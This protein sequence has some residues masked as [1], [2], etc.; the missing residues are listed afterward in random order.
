M[1]CIMMKLELL[2][3]IT[4]LYTTQTTSILRRA[5]SRAQCKIFQRGLAVWLLSED[6]PK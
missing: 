4:L 6:Y 1:I 3:I 2:A 5:I